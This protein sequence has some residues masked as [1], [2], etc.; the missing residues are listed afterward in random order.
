MLNSCWFVSQELVWSISMTWNDQLMKTWMMHS[1]RLM[2]TN[3]FWVTRNDCWVMREGRCTVF[4]KFA[5]WFKI[6][7]RGSKSLDDASHRLI[8]RDYFWVTRNDLWGWG[9]RNDRC[10]AFG[11][12]AWW[13]KIIVRGVRW[14]IWKSNVYY[15]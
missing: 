6:I 3:D 14:E 7:V 12:I 15:R 9:V 8:V 1:H 11:K 13:F 10:I 5:V 4:G 2:G